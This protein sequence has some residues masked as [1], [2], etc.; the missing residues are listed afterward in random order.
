MSSS[1]RA[2]QPHQEVNQPVEPTL[3]T[4]LAI[5]QLQKVLSFPT[6][7]TN[8]DRHPLSIR[9]A[10]HYFLAFLQSKTPI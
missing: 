7:P 8:R 6:E 10:R 4:V 3:V 2:N 1:A 9:L 5:Y